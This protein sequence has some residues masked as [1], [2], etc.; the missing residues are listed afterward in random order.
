MPQ[1]TAQELYN[2]MAQLREKMISMGVKDPGKPEGL[3]FEFGTNKQIA[4]VEP[5]TLE[6]ANTSIEKL[7]IGKELLG[8]LEERLR[9]IPKNLRSICQE[10]LDKQSVFVTFVTSQLI[11]STMEGNETDQANSEVSMQLEVH[12]KDYDNIRSRM[13]EVQELEE[14]SISELTKNVQNLI[15]EYEHSRTKIK[16][17]NAA[18]AQKELQKQLDSKT[19]ELQAEREKNNQTKDRLRQAETQ[20]Q[21]TRTKVRELESHIANE[22]KTSAEKIQQLQTNVKSLD[23]K[24]KQKD[25]AIESK[26]K[27]MQKAM[28]NSEDLV[29]KVEKQRDSFEARWFSPVF[30]KSL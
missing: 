4:P 11:Q 17:L 30:D 8:C 20:L 10:L 14:K 25:L 1:E 16:Q 24:M 2:E 7:P 6:S 9:E 29:A 5:T 3:K 27:D 19:E 26:M 21:K 18:Q 23:E 13:N 12:Q 15:D 22:E 28:R